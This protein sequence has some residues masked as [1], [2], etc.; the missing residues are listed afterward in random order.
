MMDKIWSECEARLKSRKSRFG[1]DSEFI[2]RRLGSIDKKI[3]N[4]YH[5]IG[6]GLN[7]AKCKE[8]IA[9]LEQE[10]EE[11]QAEIHKIENDEGL[12]KVLKEGFEIIKSKAMAVSEGFENRPFEDQRTL[13]EMFVKKIEI[14]DR[15][16]ARVYFKVPFEDNFTRIAQLEA[17]FDIRD[18]SSGKDGKSA[19]SANQTAHIADVAG[20]CGINKKIVRDSV[21]LQRTIQLDKKPLFRGGKLSHP[22]SS[23]LKNLFLSRPPGRSSQ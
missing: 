1:K 12:K 18:V 15:A 19:L 20:S 14:I 16:V 13:I 9:S 21:Y 17:E 22:E 7:P 23:W 11:L 5:A 2:K 8:I 4:Y 3:E 6:E 10:K